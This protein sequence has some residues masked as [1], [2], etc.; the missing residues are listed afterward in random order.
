MRKI[1]ACGCMLLLAACAKSDK[2]AASDGAM[3]AGAVTPVALSDVAGT[4]NVRSSAQTDGRTLVE[5]QM[6]TTSSTDGWSFN[7]P[8]RKPIPVRVVAV[9]AD[10]IVTETGPYESVLRKGVQVSV[11]NV[12]RLQDGKLVGTSVARYQT[13]GADSVV[14]LRFEGTRAN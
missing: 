14:Y 12:T 4:W 11:T 5:F 3:S 2:Q 9:D 13:T 6:V 7:F 10:S 1:I 8:D